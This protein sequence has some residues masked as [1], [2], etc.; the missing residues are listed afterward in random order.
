[1]FRKTFVN[2]SG[3]CGLGNKHSVRRVSFIDSDQENYDEAAI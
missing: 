2:A 3:G 1:M